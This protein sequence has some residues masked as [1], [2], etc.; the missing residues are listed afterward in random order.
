L[1][2]RGNAGE[3]FFCNTKALRGGGKNSRASVARYPALI[4]FLKKVQFPDYWY[5]ISVKVLN[6]YA[7]L[8][9]AMN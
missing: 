7:N 2:F 5:L 9:A 1:L 3:T 4:F 8:R 6:K